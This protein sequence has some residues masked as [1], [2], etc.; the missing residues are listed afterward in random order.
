MEEALLVEVLAL[1]EEAETE[2]RIGGM[3]ADEQSLLPEPKKR[4]KLHASIPQLATK[5]QVLDMSAVEGKRR[6]VY[7]RL[8]RQLDAVTLHLLAEVREGA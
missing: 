1:Y 2:Q 5:L 4:P 8:W 7:L 6:S 3:N